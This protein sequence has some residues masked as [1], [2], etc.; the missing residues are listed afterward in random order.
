MLELSLKIHFFL[1]G[2]LCCWPNSSL[3]VLF[4]LG[5]PVTDNQLCLFCAV[6]IYKECTSSPISPKRGNTKQHEEDCVLTVCYFDFLLVS[7]RS[8]FSLWLFF[9]CLF[10]S[11]FLLFAC[12]VLMTHR[13]ILPFQTILNLCIHIQTTA[14]TFMPHI[15]VTTPA[16]SNLSGFQPVFL[17]VKVIY[18]DRQI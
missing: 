6:F 5:N 8:C 2:S 10:F 3:Q 17:T 12:W 16:L 18:K 14:L 11:V 13:H 7:Y 1:H 15:L 4:K 9:F